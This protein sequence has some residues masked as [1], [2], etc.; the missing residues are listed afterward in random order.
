[1]PNNKYSTTCL[2]GRFNAKE[3][4]SYQKLE[5]DKE[6]WERNTLKADGLDK[7]K[8]KY[9]PSHINAMMDVEGEDTI[10]CRYNLK[11]NDKICLNLITN[12]KCALKEVSLWFFPYEIVL[13]TIKFD[14][15]GTDLNS[16]TKMHGYWKEW[17]GNYEMFYTTQLEQILEPLAKYTASGNASGLTKENTKIRQYQVVQI[18]GNV[19]DDEL[20]YEL[21]TFSP[22]GVV[23]NP[24]PCR[25]F[26]P[27]D[28]YFKKTIK[29]NSVSVYSNWKGLA[30]NDSFTVLAIDEVYVDSELDKD[31]DGYR[32]FEL[33]YMRCLFEEYYCFDRNNLFRER[34]SIDV[35]K[36]LEEIK[37]MERNYFYDDLS[38]DF[39]PPLMLRAMERGLGL[40]GDRKELTEHIKQ[41]YKERQDKDEQRRRT[42]QEREERE[43]QRRNE[44]IVS[45]VQLLA[46]FSIFGTIYQLSIAMTGCD[47]IPCLAGILLVVGLVFLCFVFFKIVRGGV[48]KR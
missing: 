16:L 35:D 21:G 29:E 34:E 33:L 3:G 9:Y 42:Q 38:Y 18:D 13:F 39:L 27:S 8:R 15:S 14:D 12:Y 5:N 4:F 31:G 24:D 10:I 11:L 41:A 25:S 37:A 28:D 46:A 7:L 43:Q 23:K 1:M 19:L 30:L 45:V 48:K 17:G 40:P 44:K 2:V 22:V 20:L 6:N 32:Y 36:Q 47:S 26:K